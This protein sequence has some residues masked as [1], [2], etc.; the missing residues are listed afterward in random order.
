L[1]D[2]DE[3]AYITYFGPTDIKS[4][5]SNNKKMYGVLPYVAPEVLRESIYSRK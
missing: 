3:N 5:Q 1:S 4:T 2:F